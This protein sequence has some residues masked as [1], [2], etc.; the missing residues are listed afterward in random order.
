MGEEKEKEEFREG[1]KGGLEKRKGRKE[2]QV[3]G[4]ENKE[5]K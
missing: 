2:K 1:R 4:R 3:N 5:R